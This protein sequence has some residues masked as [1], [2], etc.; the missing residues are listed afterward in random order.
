MKNKKIAEATG[1]L[2]GNTIP[3]RIMKSSKNLPQN[4]SE[5]VKNEQNK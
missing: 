2:I 1:D 4:N 5:T 3:S